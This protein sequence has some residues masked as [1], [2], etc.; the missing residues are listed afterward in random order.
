MYKA[1]PDWNKISNG[2]WE[3]VF[4]SIIWIW[5]LYTEKKTIGI[6]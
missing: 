1:K 6:N 5:G 4:D 3:F 2:N